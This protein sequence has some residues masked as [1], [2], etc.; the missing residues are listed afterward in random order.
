VIAAAEATAERWAEVRFRYGEREFVLVGPDGRSHAFSDC[1]RSGTFYELGMLEDMRSRLAHGDLVLDVGAHIGTHSV[2]LAAVCACRVIAFEPHPEAFAA[3]CENVRRNGVSALVEARCCAVGADDG[4]ATLEERTNL[5]ETRAIGSQSASDVPLT[6]LDGL[7]PLRRAAALKIDIEGGELDALRGALRLLRASRPL[8]YC[9]VK[10]QDRYEQVSDLLAAE[11][12]RLAA[13]FN[14]TPTMLFAHRGDPR[15]TTDVQTLARSFGD[16]VLKTYRA[17][18]ARSAGRQRAA[19]LAAELE[20]AE[21]RLS[22]AELRLSQAK[23]RLSIVS[24]C[25]ELSRAAA[26]RLRRSPGLW[27]GSLLTGLLHPTSLLDGA[28]ALVRGVAFDL[29]HRGGKFRSYRLTLKIG[30]GA[31]L[32]K[33]EP[34]PLVS[35]VMPV[36]DDADT[37]GA[38]ARSI[39]AQSWRNIELIAVDDASEDQSFDELVRLAR[40]DH[41]V[42][43]FRLPRTHGREF[44]MNFGLSKIRGTY[45]A[46]QHPAAVSAPDRIAYQ[47]SRLFKNGAVATV[48]RPRHRSP[49]EWACLSDLLFACDPV[50]THLGFLDA[51]AH[52]AVE[53]FRLRVENFFEASAVAYVSRGMVKACVATEPCGMPESEVIHAGER[54]FEAAV[55][56]LEAQKRDDPAGVFREF[57]TEEPEERLSQPLRRQVSDR[58]A[59]LASGRSTEAASAL[60]TELAAQGCLVDVYCNGAD[61]VPAPRASGVRSWLTRP[62]TERDGL[63]DIRFFAESEPGAPFMP[64]ATAIDAARHRVIG[65]AQAPTPLTRLPPD[66][67][68]KVSVILPTRDRALTLG[69][70]I[71]S[72]LEQSYT[73]LELIVVDDAS[74]DSTAAVVAARARAD[75]RI[76]PIRLTTNRGTYWARNVGL[77][78]ATGDL[79]TIQDDDDLSLAHRLELTVAAL[80]ARPDAVAAMAEHVRRDLLG[81]PFIYGATVVR[82]LGLHTLTVRRSFLD[83]R[84]GFYDV[85]RFG[86]DLEFYKRLV[87]AAGPGRLLRIP[88][89]YYH[90]RLAPG[91]LTTSG[92]GRMV[93][94]RGRGE[95]VLPRT[96]QAYQ[97]AYRH[98]HAEI[99][100]ERCLA[101]LPFPPQEPRPFPVPPELLPDLG[102]ISA[103]GRSGVGVSGLAL[104]VV[105]AASTEIG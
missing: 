26:K 38:A 40:T 47:L 22:Q 102:E 9:E 62:A 60:A 78:H 56:R 27:V 10:E 72:I 30:D 20:Q 90:A 33:L 58:A 80:R 2:Y 15:A 104:D 49:T 42:R 1:E 28:G 39:L 6:R 99:A 74:S 81:R 7:L 96:R 41:R 54:Y 46:F 25:L 63:L 45:I 3:L 18:L 32:G 12:Y 84:L 57:R 43:V 105:D 64:P 52:V 65:I 59:V 53:E 101:Y 77:Q 97:R 37:L 50:L 51:V 92:I 76:K 34:R 14:W 4:F 36:R 21:L 11:G 75:G 44:A 48:L 31:A 73:N 83:E 5:G 88:A 68:L 69:A 85:V 16:A 93:Y 95:L 94:G 19:D 89:V 100:A 23:L 8:V 103:H 66:A 29:R 67:P 24:A 98:W 17:N 91:S 35:V 71:D 61:P 70:A 86:G 79:V 87:A 13:S 82:A 55:S